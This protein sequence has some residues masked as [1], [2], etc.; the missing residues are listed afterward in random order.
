MIKIRYCASE[1]VLDIAMDDY[2]AAEY[3][4]EWA[5]M[6]NGPT[7]YNVRTSNCNVIDGFRVQIVL[8]A[9]KH[10]NVELYVQKGADVEV[11]EFNPRGDFV[12]VYEDGSK[13]NE[14][15]FESIDAKLERIRR[16]VYWKHKIPKED[17][18]YDTVPIHG[19]QKY[20]DHRQVCVVKTSVW[21][22]SDPETKFHV[23][24]FFK[25]NRVIVREEL[26]K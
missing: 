24:D 2:N 10:T 26:E 16:S 15:P 22:V 8:G 14:Q 3:A 25:V 13:K 12:R 17:G 11:Y 6:A 9:I 19:P 1:P 21:L 4:A 23:T 18:Y 5:A 7:E 20:M